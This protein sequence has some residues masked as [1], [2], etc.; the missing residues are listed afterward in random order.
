MEVKLG[1]L[2]WKVCNGMADGFLLQQTRR[3]GYA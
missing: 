1:K 2:D 3:D